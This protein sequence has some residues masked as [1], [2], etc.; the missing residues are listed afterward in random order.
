MNTY[1]VG[2]IVPYPG[3]ARHKVTHH[4]RHNDR[5]KIA[6]PRGGFVYGTV[7]TIFGM[8]M[9]GNDCPIAE[10]E[11]AVKNGHNPNPWV[12]QD[13]CVITNDVKYNT[14][15]IAMQEAGKEIATGDTVWI[16]GRVGTVKVSRD[17]RC[18]TLARIVL[19]DQPLAKVPSEEVR[20]VEE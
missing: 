3:V 15:R 10:M 8:A 14:E 12:N 13:S 1:T 6:D 20:Y 7:G 19:E 4:L 16:E 17:L 2:K 11:R 18:S 9:Y 5:V